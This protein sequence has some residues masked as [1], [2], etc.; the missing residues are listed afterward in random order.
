MKEN[1]FLIIGHQGCLFYLQFHCRKSNA[2]RVPLHLNRECAMLLIVCPGWF[3]PC[4]REVKYIWR[5][6]LS[7]VRA[8]TMHGLDTT[9]INIYLHIHIIHML[10]PC[11]T[12]HVCIVCW[13]DL[14]TRTT[15][16]SLLFRSFVSLLAVSMHQEIRIDDQG[17]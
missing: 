7:L 5:T 12:L 15:I 10:F 8:N 3:D 17:S 16:F 13:F 1:P 2:E 14:I 4:S 9:I 6:S 11:S